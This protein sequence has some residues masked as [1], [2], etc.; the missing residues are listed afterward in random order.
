MARNS[1]Q[2]QVSDIEARIATLVAEYSVYDAETMLLTE[3]GDRYAAQAEELL[4]QLG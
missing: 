2:S 4:G 3:I 1:S